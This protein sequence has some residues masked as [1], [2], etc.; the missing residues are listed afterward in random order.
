[1]F[2]TSFDCL[3]CVLIINEC[4]SAYVKSYALKI[5][6]YSI[7]VFV[8]IHCTKVSVYHITITFNMCETH[9]WW[10][11]RVRFTRFPG[12]G[13]D[14]SRVEEAAVCC[15]TNMCV[16]V[17][18][19]DGNR[20]VWSSSYVCVFLHDQNHNMHA[21]CTIHVFSLQY[22]V[23]GVV[24]CG[25]VHFC[26]RR[27]SAPVGTDEKPGI[28]IAISTIFYWYINIYKHGCALVIINVVLGVYLFV[29]L[30]QCC[31]GIS[32]KLGLPRAILCFFIR[33]TP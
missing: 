21:K 25:M 31:Q 33:T 19:A 12:I 4:V 30:N 7:L 17:C 28:S 26:K 22:I 14:Q 27:F 1:M 24:W 3:D 18:A 9:Q 16:W 6:T 29:M 8:Y 32:S 23:N 13:C 2:C 10:W 5:N 11:F 20:W 15:I